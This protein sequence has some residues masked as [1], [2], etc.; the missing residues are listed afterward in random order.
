MHI[1]K[2]KPGV[3]SDGPVWVCFH[4]CYMYTGNTLLALLL[5]MWRNW[6][7]DNRLIG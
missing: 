6:N 4:N 5:D 2:E 3:L 1:Y 7:N